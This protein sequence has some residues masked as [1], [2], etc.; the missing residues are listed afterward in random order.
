MPGSVPG[1]GSGRSKADVAMDRYAAGDD[2]AFGEVYDEVAPRLLS[3]LTRQTRDAARAEDLVQRTFLQMHRARGTF[4]SGSAVLPWAFAIA[5]RLFIDEL[6]R[7][8]RDVMLGAAPID[9]AIP[10][11]ESSASLVE[12]EQLA[13]MIQR[14]LERLPETQRCAFEL[15][16]FEG[17][18][19]AEAAET[20]GVTISAVKLR[21]HRAY[22]AL[23]AVLGAAIVEPDE[24]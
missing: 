21:A 11:G 9:E 5:R 13:R 24:S 23:R 20:L 4:I 16:R 17:L 3:Y 1:V 14:E 12:A 22:V 8:R 2:A 19:H 10:G 15:M 7:S 6:R 18:S